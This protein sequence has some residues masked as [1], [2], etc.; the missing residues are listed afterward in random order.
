MAQCEDCNWRTEQ[1]MTYENAD[2]V[3]RR[4]IANHQLQELRGIRVALE[5]LGQPPS[6]IMKGD[7]TIEPVDLTLGKITP[8]V[9][10]EIVASRPPASADAPG[11][12]TPVSGGTETTKPPPAA[13]STPQ[14]NK[15]SAVPS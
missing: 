8:L 14:I 11:T 9:P 15:V 12:S 13:P 6:F 4:H 10:G 3:M 1:G 5:K 2:W 7:G